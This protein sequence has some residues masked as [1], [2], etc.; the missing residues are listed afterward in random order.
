MIEAAWI[1]RSVSFVWTAHA[2]EAIWRR[3]MDCRFI[4]RVCCPEGNQV[5]LL[6]NNMSISSFW[7][8][9]IFDFVFC[10]FSWLLQ[11][12]EAEYACT[13]GQMTENKIVLAR[14]KSSGTG[15]Y[16]FTRCSRP[17]KMG[18]E[19]IFIR[20][21]PQRDHRRLWSRRGTARVKV[22]YA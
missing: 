14:N 1:S 22:G 5:D 15:T 11:G 16:V 7:V 18:T 8:A 21:V 10:P 12:S 20:A 9:F 19:P 13:Q 6:S 3:T 2:H 4:C 17:K